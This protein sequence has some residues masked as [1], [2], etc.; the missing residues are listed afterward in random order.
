[1][2]SKEEIKNKIIESA[3]E[4]FF[5]NGLKKVRLDE[6]PKQLGIRKRTIYEL[7]T[8]KT[9]LIE[10]MLIEKHIRFHQFIESKLQKIIENE[11]M[12]ISDEFR[13]I[14]K[15]VADHTSH[16]T[17]LIIDD[18]KRYVNVIFIKCPHLGEDHEE[19]FNRIYEIGLKKGFIKAH[20][21]RKI[22][23]NIMRNSFLN[24]LNYET[25]KTLPYTAEE[26]IEQIYEII[27]TGGLTNSG[28][29]DYF[30]KTETNN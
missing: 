4:K 9:D 26:V 19:I 20:I 12:W 8:S 29:E 15:Y 17:P 7:F 18:I 6:I 23:F 5:A 28:R 24:I 16:F 25:M 21:N 2:I 1:M 10:Q 27:L 3:E 14:W 13:D 22:L 11:D 30:S